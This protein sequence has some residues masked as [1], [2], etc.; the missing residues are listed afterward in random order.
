MTVYNNPIVL[1]RADPWVLKVDGEYW[2]TASDPEYDKI[3][4]RHASTINDLQK[5]PE[6]VVWRKHE[7]GVCSKYIWA[8]ELH[9]VNGAWYI[10]FAGAEH[11]FEP[12]GMPTHRMF[13]LENTDADPT[14]DNWVEKGQIVTP[15]D[16]FSLDATT[17]AIDGVQYLVW[18]QKDYDIPGNSNLYIAPMANPWTLAADPVMLT[19]PEY[20]WECIDFLVNEG[21]AFLFHDDKIFITYSASGTGVPYAVGLLTA[22]RGS[23]LMD[24]KSWTKSP[25]PVFKTCSEN[26]QYGPGHNSFT[27]SEDDSED[28]M[29]YHARNYTEIKGDPLF[30][31]NRHARVGVVRWNE[32]GTPDFGVPEPDNLWTPV[33]TDVLPPDGGPK[34]GTPAVGLAA[35]A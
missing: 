35:E 10:Y 31:P 24:P 4:I 32:D 28:L 33:T 23:D 5:A 1:Q 9:R 34:A 17:E 18:A 22:D 7:S 8:P 15:M 19:K 20:D 21:P 25:V 27:K 14:T 2:F 13:V 6:T 16:S 30:D 3:A 11:E 29:I 12:N 26:G